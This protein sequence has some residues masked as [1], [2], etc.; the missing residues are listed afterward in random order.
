MAT[1]RDLETDA[2]LD[3]GVLAEGETATAA[4]LEDARRAINRLIDQWA[5]ERLTID[6]VPATTW[7]TA[8]R[9]RRPRRWST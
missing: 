5:A 1:L 6:T 9:S 4:Q 3:L 8:S 7:A 2:L